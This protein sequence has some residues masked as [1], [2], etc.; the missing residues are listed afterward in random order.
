MAVLTPSQG[1]YLKAIFVLSSASGSTRICDVAEE[2]GV[3]KPSVC[4]A[5]KTLERMCLVERDAGRRILLTAEGKEKAVLIIDKLTI[6]R[7]FL[8][9]VLQVDM[10][11]AEKDACAMEHAVSGETLCSICRRLGEETREAI[12]GGRCLLRGRAVRHK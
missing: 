10:E 4:T 9:E 12:C 11:S 8:V 6:I 2:L 1:H 3:S 5:V 7:T